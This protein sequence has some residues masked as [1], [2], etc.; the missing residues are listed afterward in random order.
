MAEAQC[1]GGCGQLVG[2]VHKCPSCH[3]HMHPF[4]SRPIAEEGFGQP[5]LCPRCDTAEPLDKATSTSPII[6]AFDRARE[7]SAAQ[8]QGPQVE[9]DGDGDDS[10]TKDSYVD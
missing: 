5:V 10:A 9:N 2:G 3:S 8:R 7:L 6:A 4:C 1:G